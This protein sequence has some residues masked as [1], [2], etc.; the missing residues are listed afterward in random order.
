MVI[1]KDN[2]FTCYD[3]SKLIGKAWRTAATVS[4][5]VSASRSGGI[6]NPKAIPDHYFSLSDSLR[7][8]NLVETQNEADDIP[9]P[10]PLLLK[11]ALDE[12]NSRMKSVDEDP[13]LPKKYVPI[14]SQ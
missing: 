5:G 12:N 7:E 10:L 8:Q 14:L 2:N 11:Y 9:V 13:H 6:F 3:D 4:N 1:N